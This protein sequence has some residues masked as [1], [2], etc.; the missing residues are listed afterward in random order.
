MAK[1][2][3]CASTD[4]Q[5]AIAPGLFDPFVFLLSL[6]VWRCRN[7]H[8]RFFQFEHRPT[9]IVVLG[10]LTVLLLATG[11][12]AVRNVIRRIPP[13][14]PK[15]GADAS[16]SPSEVTLGQEVL[17][18][19]DHV[20][21]G[22]SGSIAVNSAQ[23]FAFTSQ[24]YRLKAIVENGFNRHGMTS[25]AVTLLD[26][27]GAQ[28][29]FKEGNGHYQVFT[30]TQVN[31]HPE[32][33]VVEPEASS[34]AV[35]VEAVPGYDWIP[36]DVPDWITI[37]SGARGTG[38]GRIDYD[39]SANTT[40]QART[41]KLAI[42][43]T[44]FEIRQRRPNA[45]QIPYRET[46]TSL[47]PPSPIFMIDQ[48]Q[49][50]LDPQAS[51]KWFFEEQP[52]RHSTVTVGPEG[53]DGVNSLIVQNGTRDQ[54]AWATQLELPRIAVEAGARYVLSVS[55]K[56]DVPSPVSI[57]F[58]QRTEPFRNCGL[59]ETVSVTGTWNTFTIPFRPAGPG[60]GAVNN[61]LSFETASIGGTLWIANVS[62]NGPRTIARSNARKLD[63]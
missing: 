37:T 63:E 49:D 6:G 47:A 20:P 46:F 21:D 2:P 15:N 35:T 39:V 60:C 16:V 14:T 22:W 23:R 40:N 44:V 58:G 17:V 62:L 32:S 3:W 29:P 12:A 45:V 38:D 30:R 50:D 43:D 53:P 56:A 25:I 55:M 52:G 54:R 31:M 19:V 57:S 61:R 10:A 59:F 9:K 8:R 24:P 28:L 7:C 48:S 13:P 5:Q 26:R 33:Q 4:V 34:R 41:A 18:N 51:W 42:G 11:V 36:R 27:N 1:S